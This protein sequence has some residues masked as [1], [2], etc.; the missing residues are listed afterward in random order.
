MVFAQEE[1]IRLNHNYI[2]TEHILLGLLRE[3]EGIAAQLLNKKG[4][5]LE[6]VRN[7]IEELVGKGKES[8]PKIL[9]YTP[10]TKTL[11]EYS[12]SEA[13]NL[14]HNYI[15]TEHLLLAF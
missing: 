12:L 4:I 14:G 11:L 15:G 7:N 3:G 8:V 10:R 5:T 13:Q 2:G 6:I 1:A 9:G